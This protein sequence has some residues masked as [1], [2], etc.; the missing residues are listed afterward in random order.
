MAGRNIAELLL[1]EEVNVWRE[2]LR[3]SQADF[4][5]LVNAA[6]ISGTLDMA[7]IPTA[8]EISAAAEEQ[9]RCIE[10]LRNALESLAKLTLS[11]APSDRP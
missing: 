9:T 4:N 6:R 1:R 10:S 2:R 11:D 7:M 3:R 5:T 8:R